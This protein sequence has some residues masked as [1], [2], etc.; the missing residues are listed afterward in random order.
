MLYNRYV[1]NYVLRQREFEV[2][3]IVLLLLHNATVSINFTPYYS[4]YYFLEESREYRVHTIVFLSVKLLCYM[5]LKFNCPYKIKAQTVYR[6]GC[7]K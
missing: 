3:V 5:I 2:S 1:S 6:T 4:K 7:T